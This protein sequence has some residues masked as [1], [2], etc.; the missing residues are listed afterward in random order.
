MGTT[1]K[2][3]PGLDAGIVMEAAE[4][5]GILESRQSW[6]RLLFLHWPV[7]P[8]VLRPVVPREL[9]LDLRDGTAWVG[10]V[11]F[12]IERLRPPLV[13]ERLGLDFLETNAR[14]YVRLPGG[15]R[16][17]WFFSLDAASCLAVGGAR[18]AHG[19][20]YHHARMARERQ[21]KVE[22]YRTARRGPRAPG[23]EVRFRTGPRLGPAQRGSLEAFLIERYALHVVRGG[24]VGTVRVFHDPYPLR[25]VVVESVSE[26]LLAAAGIERPDE[27]P[28]AH[29]S[30]GVDV[31]VRRI[32]EFPRVACSNGRHRRSA[33]TSP[34]SARYLSRI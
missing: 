7:A 16:A 23:L 32:V 24:K 18:L 9:P 15:E 10:V 1:R 4:R 13:P 28:L 3:E 31:E 8:E 20:P 19:L 25:E 12:D 17:V 29:F 22:V 11:A 21:A 26:D 27:P 6:R 5:D 14:T 34:E 2:L 30:D 33:S